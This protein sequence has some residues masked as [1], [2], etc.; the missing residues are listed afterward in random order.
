[1]ESLM[2]LVTYVSAC[3][4]PECEVFVVEDGDA[5]NITHTTDLFVPG[6]VNDAGARA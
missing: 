2:D 3:D 4:A 1:M 5:R 6:L